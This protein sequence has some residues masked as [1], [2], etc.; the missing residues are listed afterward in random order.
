MTLRFVF[1]S[2]LAAFVTV[3]GVIA[4][5]TPSTGAPTDLTASPPHQS[6]QVPDLGITMTSRTCT[7]HVP[8]L[9]YPMPPGYE[10]AKLQVT[11]N[12]QNHGRSDSSV[13]YGPFTATVD[14]GEWV[15][16]VTVSKKGMPTF[17][18]ELGRWTCGPTP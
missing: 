3:A 7:L 15:V 2:M 12:G 5:D 4:Q 10:G 11:R 6:A 14:R 17:E 16:R 1:V 13:P 9:E 8:V 18:A